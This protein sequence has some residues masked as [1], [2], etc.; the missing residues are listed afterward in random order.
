MK[1]LSTEEL[2][3]VKHSLEVYLKDCESFKRGH[4]GRF[5]EEEEKKISNKIKTI[6]EILI[7][8]D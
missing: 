3:V 1:N 2:I 6:K 5:T 4:Y 7:K 8:L